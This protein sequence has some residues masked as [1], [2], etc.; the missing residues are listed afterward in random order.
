MITGFIKDNKLDVYAL[1]EF[2]RTINDQ[3]TN[4]VLRSD[5][6]I[7]CR[8]QLKVI[9]DQLQQFLAE[10]QEYCYDNPHADI[11][12]DKV[13]WTNLFGQSGNNR[14]DIPIDNYIFTVDKRKSKI[15]VYLVYKNHGRRVA[16]GSLFV[17][18]SDG[19]QQ[20]TYLSEMCD[21]YEMKFIRKAFDTIESFVRNNP[22]RKFSDKAL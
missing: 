15:I 6:D 19:T 16:L 2:Q 12:L 1:C 9:R 11:E 7:A 13:V 4:S 18:Q 17:L 10:T 5:D 22:K 8:K 20:W 14:Y 21:D 3:L